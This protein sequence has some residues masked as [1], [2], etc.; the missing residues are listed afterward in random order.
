MDKQILPHKLSIVFKRRECL[1]LENQDCL[2]DRPPMADYP[3]FASGDLNIEAYSDLHHFDIKVPGEHTIDGETFDAEIQMFHTS[4]TAPRLSSLGV[5]IRAD[6]GLDN[7]EYQTV[8]NE[9]QSIYD[10]NALQ[11]DRRERQLQLRGS[12]NANTASTDQELAYLTDAIQ[13]L[14]ETR[15]LQR[16][17]N[18][19]PYSDYFLP[20]MF[21]FRYDG[22][23][24]EP[25]CMDLTWWVMDEPMRI[26]RRQLSQTKRILFSHVDANCN[27]TSVHN[28]DQSVTRPIEALG[29][30]REIQH[31]QTGD[32]RSDVSKGRP[33][34]KRCR[35]FE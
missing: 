1:D 9:F 4:L 34:A 11:C 32:F 2:D 13:N 8:L 30:D 31:C 23:I 19:N 18:F 14:T 27:P 16:N 10:L 5:P 21:F 24:T 7:P 20:T 6:D 26:S 28:A 22:S 25:P 35:G 12:R 17:P 29:E 15:K 3:R 33:P